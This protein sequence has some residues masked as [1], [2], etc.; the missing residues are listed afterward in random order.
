MKIILLTLALVL[1]VGVSRAADFPAVGV[2]EQMAVAD[3]HSS[4]TP[5][6]RNLIFV[7]KKIAGGT[8]LSAISDSFDGT[9][10]CLVVKN[11]T[12]IK[13]ENLLEKYGWDS[14][15]IDH[16]KNIKGWS[17]I[18]EAVLVEPASQN[19]NMRDLVSAMG[20][21]GDISPFSA[22]IVSGGMSEVKKI[23]D[24]LL[25]NR[26]DIKFSVIYNK[27]EYVANYVFVI[28]GKRKIFSEQLFP[29]E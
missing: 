6:R 11:Q 3:A 27:N 23:G 17:Y 22:A 28:N 19:G 1:S 8:M 4:S 29:A 21:A 14:D 2:W 20:G 16:L 7:D 12:P 5:I 15:D 26:R 25:L 9:M 18:Y 13:F 10:C 24:T